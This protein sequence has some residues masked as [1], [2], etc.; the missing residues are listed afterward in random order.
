MS[1]ARKQVLLVTGAARGI[2]AAIVQLAAKEGYAIAINYQYAANQA[3]ALANSINHNG[4]EA[5]AIQADVSKESDVVR[6]FK[7]IDEKL[8]VIS[9]LVN[10]AGIVDQKSSVSRMSYERLQKMFSTNVIGSFVCSRE[11]VIR[12]STH[13]GGQGGAIVNLSSI[14]SRL[15]APGQYVDYAASKAAIDT[16][17]IGLAKEVAGE[18]IRVNS[19]APGIIDTEIHASGGEPERAR[20]SAGVIPM[21][22]AGTAN[23]VANAVLWLLSAQ[24]SYVTGACIDVGG[25]R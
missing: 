25:G 6:M 7:C 17:T 16:L 11:A 12:M 15:G 13:S 10:N 22:R 24:A 14:V 23:E 19:V 21:G 5:L 18:G 8:G 4:G 1:H 3:D 9:A 2:G 20:Q